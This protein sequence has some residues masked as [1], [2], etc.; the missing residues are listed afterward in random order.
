MR[1]GA[2]QIL[3]RA[4]PTEP[5]GNGSIVRASVRDR[6]VVQDNDNIGL[7]EELNLR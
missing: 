7:G 3:G 1:V 5:L 4:G 6:A 2:R